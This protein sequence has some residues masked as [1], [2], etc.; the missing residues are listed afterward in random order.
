MTKVSAIIRCRN[1]YPVILGTINTFLNEL[2]YSGYEP[3]IIVVDNMSEDSTAEILIDRYRRWTRCGLM[4]VIKYTEKASTWNAINAGYEQA[5]GDFI[6]I[7]DA[8]I[9]MRLGTSKLL[10]DGCSAHSGLWFPAVQLWGDIERIKRYQFDV[11]LEQKFWGDPCP[12]LPEG[13]DGTKPY[14]A[15]MGGACLLAAAHDE[16]EKF[17]LFDKAFGAYG[18]G[19][20]YLC[21]KWW[22]L[23][24]KVWLEPRALVRHAFG[25]NARWIKNRYSRTCRNT[26]YT[27]GGVF[28]KQLY[29]NDEFLAY[30]SGYR[31]PNME[32]YYNFMLAAYL[33]GGEEWGEHIKGKFMQKVREPTALE[34][35]YK[36][37]IENGKEGREFILSH[38]KIPLNDLLNDPPWKACSRHY[39]LLPDFCN[40]EKEGTGNRSRS[41][42]LDKCEPQAT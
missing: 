17:G 39:V 4:K 28:K 18:G 7:A 32:F 40:E 14:P 12:F 8:H 21:L 27:R 16:I 29:P 23:G 15:A 6:L 19:E 33:I 36:R 30:S 13:E 2:E 31:L 22:M 24:S 5:T 42:S 3:E 20:P 38:M 34:E 9:S 26:V 10:I 11:R 35:T 37:A 25:T 41:T 1:E